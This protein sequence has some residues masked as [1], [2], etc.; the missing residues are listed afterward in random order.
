M[1]VKQVLCLVMVTLLRMTA[2]SIAEAATVEVPNFIGAVSEAMEVVTAGDTI[3][4]SN[5]SEHN[6]SFAYHDAFTIKSGVKVIAK[7]NEFPIIDGGTGNT[8][9]VIFPNGSSSTTLMEGNFTIRGGTGSVVRLGNGDGT[10]R[11]CTLD[12]DYRDTPVALSVDD[13]Q[14][15]VE[16]CVIETGDGT[17]I[18]GNNIA[19]LISGGSITVAGAGTGILGYLNGGE[20]ENLTISVES[21]T[22]AEINYGPGEIRNCQ[23][24]VGDGVGIEVNADPYAGTSD[25]V[26]CTVDV[27][28][29]DTGNIGIYAPGAGLPT[30]SGCLVAV[31]EGHGVL[32][33]NGTVANCTVLGGSV[34]VDATVD[35]TVYNCIASGS[36]VGF[37]GGTG[38]TAYYCIADGSL[39]FY[40]PGYKDGSSVA[41]DPLFCDPGGGEYTLRIDSYGNPGNNGSGELIGA[42]PVAC[43]YDTLER[44][45]VLLADAEAEVWQDLVVT[46]GITLTMNEGSKLL[47]DNHDESGGGVYP[48][49]NELIVQDGGRV[50]ASGVSEGPVVFGSSESPPDGWWGFTV[51]EDAAVVVENGRI[52]NAYWPLNIVGGDSCVVRNCVFEGAG[53]GILVDGLGTLVVEHCNLG[54]H[55]I[56]LDAEDL[57]YGLI[58]GDTLSGVTTNAP[59]VEI[60]GNRITGRDYDPGIELSG[61]ASASIS[62]NI[63]TGGAHSSGIE[64]EDG[65]ATLLRNTIGTD[66]EGS[67]NKYGL[68]I[69][70]AAQVV[71][72]DSTD[73][74]SD[75]IFKANTRGLSCV[76]TDSAG[77]L[78]RNNRFE[79]NFIGAFVGS[80]SQG[81]Y[82]D[83]G[84][85]TQG[86]NSFVDTDSLCIW[87]RNTRDPSPILAIG[88]WFGSYPFTPCWAGLVV[89][90]DPLQSEPAGALVNVRPVTPRLGIQGIWPN[91]ATAGATIEFSVGANATAEVQVFDVAG[92]LVRTLDAAGSGE[93]RQVLWDARDQNG[94]PV[95]TGMYFV[96]AKANGRPVGT[97][98]LLVT[99]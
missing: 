83:L 75:N 25:I 53:S 97:G 64:I 3:L 43:A 95:G 5:A 90:D 21:G 51:L 2:T 6:P 1:K 49:E 79:D 29:G 12:A 31:P 10:L 36:D 80:Q 38:R 35:G 57:T 73:S 42:L 71:I 69:T 86:K 94:A 15:T 63:I 46:G 72:G 4:V 11:G 47:F 16:D 99:R 20:I 45:T 74:D 60:S 61:D 33:S 48:L 9:T 77:A 66:V 88:N 70:G 41:E 59:S 58:H 84:S 76:W 7:E 18:Y 96:R 32:L 85:T 65:G 55:E 68:V 23:V 8:Y 28:S 93:F 13:F 81:S 82:L 24:S 30:I 22:G 44:N 89:A 91:P 27:T 34:G 54:A 17:G 52:V 62:E 78:V 56:N 98:R 50:L 39:P 40:P 87:N 19:G 37:W 67:Q 14:G 26:G 92:R